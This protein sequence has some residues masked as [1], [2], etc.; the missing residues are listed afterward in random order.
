MRHWSTSALVKQIHLVLSRWDCTL[1]QNNS[2]D[3][4]LTLNLPHCP[5]S[6]DVTA[7]WVDSL[8]NTRLP[9]LR[10][11]CLL[12]EMNNYR[13]FTKRILDGHKPS[14]V[15]YEHTHTHYYKHSHTHAHTQTHVH[16]CT[17]SGIKLGVHRVPWK[18][19]FL[20]EPY[21]WIANIS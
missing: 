20:E 12:K 1:A 6:I 21:S 2:V 8:V 17:H 9:N 16:T 13:N 15:T 11:G 10:A 19:L 3:S 18:L 7:G 4:N 5:V 14:T